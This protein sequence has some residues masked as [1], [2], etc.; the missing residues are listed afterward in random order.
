MHTW[1]LNLTECVI[2]VHELLKQLITSINTVTALFKFINP[3]RRPALLRLH[4]ST[5]CIP[6]FSPT[7]RDAIPRLFASPVFPSAWFLVR[8]EREG[9]RPGGWKARP[10]G[11][12]K[13]Q[14]P[15]FPRRGRRR[16]GPPRCRPLVP[17]HCPVAMAATL[18]LKAAASGESIMC[19]ILV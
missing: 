16:G 17:R 9:R 3:I 15:G 19:F 18:R 6:L 4:P 11:G 12:W 13:E 5:V 7:V 2:P 14:R 8:I 1:S 10:Q